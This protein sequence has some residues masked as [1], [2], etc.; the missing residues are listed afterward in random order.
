VLLLP[1]PLIAASGGPD[2]GG[3]VFTDSTEIGGPPHAVLDVDALE[4]ATLDLGADG[5]EAV[6]LPFSFGW[7]G[8]PQDVATVVADGVLLFS[9]APEDVACPGEPASW[10]GVAAFG[11]DLAAGTVQ[12]ATAGRYPYRA[13]VTQWQA[14]HA[15][16]GGEGRVQAWLL[17]GRDEAVVVLDD[18]DF[19]DASVDGGATAV[20][21]AQGAAGV[22]LAWSCDGGLSSGSSAWF[23]A[24]GDR[25]TADE[26]LSEDLD[27]A[28][29][30]ESAFQYAGR[31]LA[32]GDVDGEG[33]GDVVVGNPTE[34]QAFVLLGGAG[35]E[36]TGALSDADVWI[37]DSAD[38]SLSA[39]MA[40]ADLDGDGLPDL[41]LGAPGTDG[42]S[43]SDVGAVRLLAGGSIG[44]TRLV[45]DG[46]RTLLGDD[47]MRGGAGA[48]LAAGDVDGD[49]YLD[50][51]IG[52]PTDDSTT[53]DAGA[54]YL[55]TGGATAL[56][57]ATVDL[58]TAP[59]WTGEGLLDG[60]GTAVA[61]GDLDGDGAAEIVVGAPEADSAVGGS[62]VTSG[63]RVYV[64]AG[65]T[66]LAGGALVDEAAVVVDGETANDR[67]GGAVAVGD[68]DGDDVA[69]L[70][71]GV[72]YYDDP[73]S[74]AGGA[75]AFLDP[76][77]GGDLGLSDADVVVTGGQ[78]SANAG[79]ALAVGDVDGDGTADLLV[80]APNMT[81][82]ATGG[83]LL[84]IFTDPLAGGGSLLDADHRLLGTSTGGALGSVLAVLGP[85]GD[86]DGDGLPEIWVGAPLDDA[87][88][89]DAAGAAYG[90][91][92]TPDFLDLD[93]DGF[94]SVD[95]GG[96]DCDDGDAAV[97]PGAGE[98][99]GTLVDEDC[100]GWIDDVLVHRE[101]EGWWS[102]D[103]GEELGSVSPLLYDFEDATLG[104]DVSLLYSGEGLRFSTG[105]DLVAAASVYG[106]LP[107]GELGAAFTASSVNRVD[108]VFDEL[109]D[110]V[111]LRVLAPDGT[112][113]VSAYTPD[114]TLLPG[115]ELDL[116]GDG[117]PGGLFEGFTFSEGI[118]RLRID[119]PGADGWGLDDIQIVWASLTDRDGDG[120]AE[121]EGDCDD[122]DAAVSPAATEILG[123]GVDDDCDGVIDGGD[124]SVY[125][126]HDAW[127]L[128]AGIDSQ[129]VDFEAL[130]LGDRPTD[131]YAD[132][133]VGLDGNLVV[134]DDVDG[135][136]PRDAQ[137][138]RA[139]GAATRIDFE[140]PQPAVALYLLD[141]GGDIELAGERGGASVASTTLIPG[142][143]DIA[144]G[145]FVGLVFDYA[146]DSLVVTNGS[147]VDVWGVD[148]LELSLLGLD[149]ADGDGF[150]EAEGDCDDSDASASPDG[151]EV[152]YDGVDGDCSGGSDYDADGDGFETDLAGGGDC[153]DGDGSISPDADEIWYDGVDSDCGGDSD[154][155][156]DGD[157]HDDAAWGGDDCDDGDGS[158]SPDAEETWYDGVDSN[159][160]GA[161]DYDADGD[162]YTGGGGGAGAPAVTDCDDSDAEISP[163][164]T[165]AWYDGVDSDCDGLSDFDADGDGFDDADWGG[166]DCDDD[167]AAVYPDAPGEVCYDGVDTDCDG[168]SDDDCDRDGY[169]TDAVGGADCDDSDPAVN[170]DATDAPGDGIDTNCDGAPEFDDD[171]DG[172]DGV[173][174][175]GD[176][177]DDSD[178]SIHPGADETWYD[179]VDSDCAG[180]DDDDADGDGYAG[181]AAGG[182]DCD[183]TD[184]TVHPGAVDYYYDGIDSDCD[185]SMDYDGDGDGYEADWYGGTD[186][187]D[188]DA[189]VHPGAEE[190]WY[191]GVDSDCDGLS[192]YDADGDGWDSDAWSGMDCDDEDAAIHPD[193]TEI[194]GDGVDQDCDGIDDVDADGDGWTSTEDCDDGDAST[195]PGADEV[196]YDGVDGDCSGTGAPGDDGGDYDADGDGWDSEGYGGLDCDDSDADVFP[197][198]SERWYD[199]VDA[200]CAGDD[201]YDADGD[202]WQAAA[203]GGGDCDDADPDR[204]PG[205]KVDD[206]GHGDEDCDDEV[207][208][209][210]AG[211]GGSDDGGAAD[212]GAADGGAADGGAADGGAADGG[213]A[214]GGSAD[215]GSADGG[216]AD[217]GS[218]DGGSADGGHVDGGAGDGGNADGGS[219]DGGSDQ[220]PPTSSTPE[221]TA[222]GGCGGA[223]RAAG[224][225]LILGPG[226]FV[227]RRRR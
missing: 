153:D 86:G 78:G 6:D 1:L 135:A 79:A 101:V 20:V 57:G 104:D 94:V 62:T 36:A 26:R 110:A 221:P 69:D 9:G 98:L 207:D 38:T 114:G 41:A 167:D 102:W 224:L 223:G 130:A 2:E 147:S 116:R 105:G 186:C 51:A 19:G 59:R 219:G 87:G 44:G 115:L 218:A 122:A 226:L 152:W 16:A 143:E 173:E 183:D 12:V 129:L 45:D 131:D 100:D 56:T 126:D 7:Y 127:L 196:W 64:V 91:E 210:C 174:D 155:D 198:A 151:T 81:A 220:V 112:Y 37:L 118:D 113:T 148:D 5:S 145:V 83:G 34:S 77:A 170:P 66:G 46:D 8:E 204:N 53:T 60:A 208:E 139:T 200:D 125:T 55:W 165:E 213:S 117:R 193:A 194:V 177:C 185:G 120:Y 166:D 191:D 72:P 35:A 10:S 99:A 39:G 176:D 184:P 40:V 24:Q 187:D 158:I 163:D 181:T 180:D 124:L 123:N 50:L 215:G 61:V 47:G 178:P 71:V 159:C 205:V 54:V 96:I 137:A 214:D 225:V 172:Y 168:W 21:G 82:G 95:A 106:T 28:W 13:F 212:G 134:V 192:D 195:Y 75:F 150:T 111:G 211:D 206:C 67:A 23:G 209:D 189:A 15:A 4:S 32:V 154:Y 22:G 156:A 31:S 121:A 201:D 107:S 160:D 197:G 70:V 103:V 119:G 199:G 109:V 65:G 97:Y 128:A 133:G 138:G 63:G 14:P 80:T 202:G 188:E 93:G 179:G 146:V 140:E 88:G 203:W 164:A 30:G 85:E 73:L 84:G 89:I 162:G 144:G 17:E 33:H 227:T 27:R 142:G 76:L 25:P 43:L 217:G 42:S 222:C 175:G 216:S 92:L 141:V 108:L 48:A 52:A 171:G 68:L 18:I 169:D 3:L 149:D 58:A 74:A 161:D 11:D 157:G 29:V 182:D 132:V 90:F 136:A 190:T 49:G